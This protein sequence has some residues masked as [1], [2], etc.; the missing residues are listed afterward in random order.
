MTLNDWLVESFVHVLVE[1][2]MVGTGQSRNPDGEGRFASM[3]FLAPHI[4]HKAAGKH[5]E[6]QSFPPKQAPTHL[7]TC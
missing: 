2:N 5:D 1:R 4:L 7:H 6:P 3:Q